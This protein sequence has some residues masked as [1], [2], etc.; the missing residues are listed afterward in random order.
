MATPLP[1]SKAGLRTVITEYADGKNCFSS[2][3]K[4]GKMD[5]LFENLGKDLS[6]CPDAPKHVIALTAKYKAEVDKIA[7]PA[8][9]GP[10]A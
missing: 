7:G 4:R 9:A 2:G 8:V 3:V 5:A 10:A 6:N 1:N